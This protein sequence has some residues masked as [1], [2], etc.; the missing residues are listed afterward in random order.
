VIL[1]SR[2]LRTSFRPRGYLKS[3]G[4]YLVD[5]LAD[6]TNL[7]K[8]KPLKLLS[9]DGLKKALRFVKFDLIVFSTLVPSAQALIH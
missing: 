5:P 1:V 7:K 3:E 2:N 6:K 9:V 4:I 8:S